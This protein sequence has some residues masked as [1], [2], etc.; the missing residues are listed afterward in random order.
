MMRPCIAVTMG[1]PAGVGPELC[2][3]ALAD[4]R[5]LDAAVPVVIGNA[6]VLDAVAR[7]LDL[8]LEADPLHPDDLEGAARPE[9]PAIVDMHI[10]SIDEVEPGRVRAACGHVAYDYITFAVERTLTGHFE[11]LATA[12]IC[13]TAMHAAGVHFPGHT[14]ILQHMTGAPDVVMMLVGPGLAVSLVTAHLPLRRVPGAVTAECVRRT[15]NLTDQAMRRILGRS[16]RIAVL[17][18]NPHAGESG[19]FGKQEAKAIEP[20]VRAAADRGILVS[21][22]LPPDTAFTE[23]AREQHDAY[24]AMYHDQ[25]LIPFK[26]LCFDQGVNVTLGIPIVRTSVDHGTAF[27]IAWQGTASHES[28]VAA[29]LL[30]A[31]L[32]QS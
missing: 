27:D 11:A 32:C 9:R 15:I 7:R 4:P 10:I 8:P 30:A 19:L 25:G 20:A 26:T 28:L 3:R 14:E 5:V 22:P 24:V 21:G 13:K 29:I 6:Q 18:L 16:P 12:P 31:K 1:D 2:L 17:G 23:R